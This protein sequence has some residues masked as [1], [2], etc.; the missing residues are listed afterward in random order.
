MGVL[1]PAS[2]PCGSCPYRRDVPSGVWALEEYQ[3]LAE[4]DKETGQQPVG[5]FLCHRQDGRVCAG[6]AG[7]HDMEHALAIRIGAASRLDDETLH[8]ILDYETDVP[9]FASGREAAIHGMRELHKPSAEAKRV[10]EKM[11]PMQR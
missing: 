1:P 11:R 9:L 10:M 3:K 4:Y 6:W 8:A 5:I 7:C 2:K